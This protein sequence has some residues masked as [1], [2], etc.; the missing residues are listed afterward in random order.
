[1]LSYNYSFTSSNLIQ[2]KSNSWIKYIVSWFHEFTAQERLRQIVYIFFFVIYLFILKCFFKGF[3]WLLSIIFG[4]QIESKNVVKKVDIVVFYIFLVRWQRFVVI[5]S[6]LFFTSCIKVRQIWFFFLFSHTFIRQTAI[7][8]W[9]AK[10]THTNTTPHNDVWCT[11]IYISIARGWYRFQ[12]SVKCL[13]RF[14]YLFFS[15][16]LLFKYLLRRCLSMKIVQ[17]NR[18]R[19][20]I[21]DHAK[22]NNSYMAFDEKIDD[23]EKG[24]KT[25]LAKAFPFNRRYSL[26]YMLAQ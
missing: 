21:Y 9:S 5:C 2:I 10:H 18:N 4:D 6:I 16:I 20:F 26:V 1:M 12:N 11:Q 15:A 17:W 14:S 7:S 13:H 24:K 22:N 25:T 23:R 19:K 3:I 8:I